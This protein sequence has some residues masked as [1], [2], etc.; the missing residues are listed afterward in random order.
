VNAMAAGRQWRW[1]EWQQTTFNVK[2]YR[3][4]IGGIRG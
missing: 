3:S 1:R 4:R 2:L